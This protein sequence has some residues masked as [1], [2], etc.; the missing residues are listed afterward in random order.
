MCR[1]LYLGLALLTQEEKMGGSGS[2]RKYEPLTTS[3][4]L[5]FDL[6]E[7]VKYNFDLYQDAIER[8]P[9]KQHALKLRYDQ[10][11]KTANLYRKDNPIQEEEPVI[12]FK[13]A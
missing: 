4:A 5:R 3:E 2:G 10:Y 7:T 11:L 6:E 1:D 9:S 12:E 13:S 8:F